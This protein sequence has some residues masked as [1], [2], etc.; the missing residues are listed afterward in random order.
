[1]TLFLVQVVAM[2]RKDLAIELRSPVRFVGVAFFAVVLI[3]MV[4][5]AAGSTT[6]VLEQ[7]AGGTL[8]VGL[9]LTSTRALDQSFATE[10]AEGA[11]EELVLWPVEPAAIFLGKAIA[12]TVVLWLVAILLVPL[13]I[14]VY[15]A[16]VRGDWPLLAAFLALGCTAL[17]GPGTLFTA[18]TS[19]ARGSS[20]L[21]PLLLFPLVV[22]ALMAAARGTTVVLEGD[23]L[24]QS[25]GWL[26]ILVVFNLLHWTLSTVL[27]GYVM[28]ST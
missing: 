27:F 15:D 23:L 6:R 2:A 20:V 26:A 13:V 19:R 24:G 12:N 8:W 25:Q 9:L 17:A 11:F 4:A 16:E 22:P 3:L 21:L 5:F 28:E 18:I 7:I 14:A 10:H 1:M